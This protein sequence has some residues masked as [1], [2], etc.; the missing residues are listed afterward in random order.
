MRRKKLRS[1]QSALER[2]DSIIA[3]VQE[4]KDSTMFEKPAD[5]RPHSDMF[6]QSCDTGP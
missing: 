4:V 5:D 3:V 2:E 1:I 6:R